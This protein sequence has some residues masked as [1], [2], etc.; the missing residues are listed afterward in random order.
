MKTNYWLLFGMM[1]SAHLWAQPAAKP[2]AAA[3]IATS[4]AL[5]FSPPS[6]LAKSTLDKIS[7]MTPLFDGQTLRGWKASVKGTNATDITKAWTVKEGAM[8]SLGEG[9]GVLH[10]KEDKLITVE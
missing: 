4:N 7:Q 3:E 8:A 2:S 5:T 1:I 10:A 6:P 9:R